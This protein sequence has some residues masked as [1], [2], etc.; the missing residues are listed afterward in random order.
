MRGEP[1]EEADGRA[2]RH[3]QD[4][5]KAQPGASAADQRVSAWFKNGDRH[6]AEPCFSPAEAIWLGASPRFL[7]QARN[8]ARQHVVEYLE[9]VY[10]TD[11][12]A[13]EQHLSPEERLKLHQ[14]PKDVW[15]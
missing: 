1:D 6:L 10:E 15:D 9:K 5:T 12:E 2:Q 13:K 14:G 3:P 8:S 4:S 7:N 11:A